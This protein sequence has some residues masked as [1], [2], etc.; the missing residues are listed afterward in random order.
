MQT[1]AGQLGVTTFSFTNELLEGKLS[2]TQILEDALAS[3][4]PKVIEI[5]GPQ[6]FRNYPLVASSELSGLEQTLQSHEAKVHQLGIYVDRTLSRTATLSHEQVVETIVKQIELAESIGA[7]FARLGLGLASVSELEDVLKATQRSKVSLLLEV[8]GTTEPDSPV[9]QEI[10]KFLGDLQTDSLGLVFDTSLC[11]T[12]LPPTYLAALAAAG[13]D[14]SLIAEANEIW[15]SQPGGAVRG[16]VFSKLM[17]AARND[18]AVSLALTL[19]T[20]MGRTKV[21][22]WL[23][24]LDYVQAVHLKYW[25]TFD[26]DGS[27]SDPMADLIRELLVRGFT[28]PLISEWGGHEWATLERP[29]LQVFE[30]HRS[31]Y[32]KALVKAGCKTLSES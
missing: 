27:L 3:G 6:H 21:S 31:I 16:F 1:F 4:L 25:D 29:S 22:D 32:D 11:M 23:A 15:Q 24:A 19:A 5:D 10:L 7:K 26:E 2:S 20:R 12:K 30:E 18:F 9:V 13:F 14:S 28:G 8:Q 17:P